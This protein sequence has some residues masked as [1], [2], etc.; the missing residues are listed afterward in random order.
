MDDVG[1][2]ELI[3]RLEDAFGQLNDVIGRLEGTVRIGA[4]SPSDV[5]AHLIAHEQR[6]LVEVAAAL[7]GDTFPIDLDANDAFNQGAVFSSRAYP[8]ETIH[9]AWLESYA[10]VLEFVR[11]LP[12]EVLQ[13]PNAVT[14][15]LGDT[16]DGALAN[17]TY[18]HYLEHLSRLRTILEA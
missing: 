2:T 7:R 12:D 9:R 5:L 3:A 8:F 18:A 4:W 6:A 11:A 13:S 16:I 14:D 17:N 10:S 15:V 1:K